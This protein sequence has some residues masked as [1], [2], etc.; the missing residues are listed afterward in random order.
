MQEKAQSQQ[1]SLPLQAKA[2]QEK[3]ALT[4]RN[5][6]STS[7]IWRGDYR[8]WSKVA[9]CI[10]RMDVTGSLFSALQKV[11]VKTGHEHQRPA[12]HE[13]K[14]PQFVTVGILHYANWYI[15][16]RWSEIYSGSNIVNLHLLMSFDQS[17]CAVLGHLPRTTR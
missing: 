17:G 8:P 9:Y 16:R 13:D 4:S 2:M 12:S 7:Q 10:S 1:P 14:Q 11:S 15:S 6:L 5:H 3:P